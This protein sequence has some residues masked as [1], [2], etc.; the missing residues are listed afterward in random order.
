MKHMKHTTAKFTRNLKLN[1]K[2]KQ[3][4]KTHFSR[5]AYAWFPWNLR[6]F[7]QN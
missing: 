4:E 5:V 6:M 3:R 7:L 2:S 1:A